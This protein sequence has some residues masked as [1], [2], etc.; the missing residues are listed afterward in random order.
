MSSTDFNIPKPINPEQKSN[1][2][3][4]LII[5]SSGIGLFLILTILHLT[6]G[7]SNIP[8]MFVS[9]ED[10]LKNEEMLNK[11]LA[12]LSNKVSSSDMPTQ[13]NDSLP[14]MPI[15]QISN[16]YQDV[17]VNSNNT[18]EP[19]KPSKT[20]S[21]SLDVV[22]NVAAAPFV[23]APDY[24]RALA[25]FM[26]LDKAIN[27]EIESQWINLKL[28]VNAE[29]ERNRLAQIQLQR[30]QAES[31]SAKLQAETIKLIKEV[32]SNGYDASQVASNEIRHPNVEVLS[33]MNN[34][35]N[36]KADVIIDG[37]LFEEIQM[38]TSTGNLYVKSISI[39]KRC[40]IFEG[41]N[42]SN[43]TKCM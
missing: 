20:D 8:H 30:A 17:S 22:N 27:P 19:S 4:V 1:N 14:K 3:K 12:T 26:M 42:S 29:R 15:S 37:E 13:N 43:L 33:V 31:Q 18:S 39:V 35:T 32:K 2:K 7:L 41:V 38:G 9:N 23:V 10:E 25:V 6:V 11:R 40:V 34:G 36:I 24:K 5:K 28:Q 16:R 21:K